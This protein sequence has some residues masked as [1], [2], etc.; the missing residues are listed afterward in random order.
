MQK[1]RLE[2]QSVF[3]RKSFFYP[4]TNKFKAF[5][6]IRSTNKI[7]DYGVTYGFYRNG[8]NECN[9]NELGRLLIYQHDAL[10]SSV[11]KETL[12]LAGTVISIPM[13]ISLKV[14]TNPRRPYPLNDN[15][16]AFPQNKKHKLNSDY[17]VS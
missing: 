5:L 16:K 17:E 6:K 14:R 15:F 11:G 10:W 13:K 8:N 7:D 12:A 4:L 3:F 1:H 9:R 2:S